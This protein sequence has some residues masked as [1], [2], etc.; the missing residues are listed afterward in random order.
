MPRGTGAVSRAM[1]SAAR[2]SSPA[3]KTKS[4]AAMRFAHIEALAA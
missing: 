2:A 3:E 1:K 4:D